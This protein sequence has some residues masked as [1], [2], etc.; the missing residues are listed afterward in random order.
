MG[1]STAKADPTMEELLASIRKIITDDVTIKPEESDDDATFLGDIITFKPIDRSE[2]N[3]LDADDDEVLHLTD[4]VAQDGSVVSLTSVQKT[5]EDSL[6]LTEAHVIDDEGHNES[7]KY[8]TIESLISEKTK[9]EAAVAFS[10]L[11]KMTEQM[12]TS[13]ETG[14]FGQK[15]TDQVLQELL[16]P[17]LKEWLDA[18]LPS[19]V[20]WIVTEQI[21]KMTQEAQQSAKNR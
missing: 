16:R 2:N 18:H 5:E 17:L 4:M 9:A 10:S 12:E 19:L 21:E 3:N 1:T 13:I 11:S 14:G 8:E 20:K 15:T 7:S 6:E